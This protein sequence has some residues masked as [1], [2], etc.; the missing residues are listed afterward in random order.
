MNTFV[1]NHMNGSFMQTSHWRHVKQNWGYA[2]IVNRGKENKI[3]GSVSVLIRRMPPAGSSLLYAPRGP[4][5]EFDDEETLLN[6]KQGL[7]ALAAQHNAYMLKMDPDVSIANMQFASLM[8][9]MGFIQKKSSKGFESIQP[10]FNYRLYIDGRSEEKLFANLT[11]KTRYNVRVA[12]KKGV[13]VTVAGKEALDDFVRLMNT[14]GERN[15]FFVRPKSYFLNFLDALGEHARLYMAYYEGRAIAG[16]I[17]TNFGRKTCYVY[18][19]SDNLFRNVM[20]NYLLQ[21]EM[22]RWAVQTDCTVYDFQGVSGNLEEKNN[23]LYGLYRFKRGFNGT[24][25]ELAGEF[26]FLYRP[27]QAKLLDTA[28]DIYNRLGLIR[29]KIKGRMR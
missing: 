20:P 17:A 18:G 28:M 6:L 7:D 8:H 3:N 25:D 16:A 2:C 12:K 27:M 4:V 26:D 23:P 1:A 24:L 10:R 5:C 29:K 19:A 13:S 14:T 15:D 11:Q 22:I 21:W 9:S